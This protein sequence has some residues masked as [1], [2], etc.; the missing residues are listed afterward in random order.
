MST[1]YWFTG[2]PG[3]GKTT[4]AKALKKHIEKKYKTTVFH[5]DGDDLRA[6]NKNHNYTPEGRIENMIT[7]QRIAHFLSNKGHFVVVA[8]VSPYRGIRDRFKE[9]ADCKEIYV[10]TT[11]IRGR[12]KNHSK[13]YEPPEKDYLHI[14]TTNK[15]VTESLNDIIDILKP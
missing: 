5:I 2:Q 14:D 9:A 8:L 3:H 6:L 1:I 11:E 10:V 4:L 15:T 13:D 12:E 7:A